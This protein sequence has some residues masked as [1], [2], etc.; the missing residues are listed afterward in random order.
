MNWHM[1]EIFGFYPGCE[2]VHLS[3]FNKYLPLSIVAEFHIVSRIGSTTHLYYSG[4]A[5]GVSIGDHPIPH[6]K[7]A[8]LFIFNLQ[9]PISLKAAPVALN[10]LN[11]SSC[12]KYCTYF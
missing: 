3:I 5:E 4:K 7:Q 6:H 12:F 9:M 8:K 11:L 10:I 1:A 2:I